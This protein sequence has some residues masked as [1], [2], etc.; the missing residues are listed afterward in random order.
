MARIKG[1]KGFP[2][3][4]ET[5][6]KIS[7]A[8]KGKWIKFN[9]DYCKKENEEKES[10]FKKKNKHFCNIKCYALFRKEKMSFME[11]PAYKGI[12]KEN[13]SKQIYH[14][15]YCRKNPKRISHLKSIRYAREKGAIG[16]HTLEMWENLKIEFDNKCAFCRKKTN[17]TKDH[18]IPLSEGGTN[19]IDN[20]Q[21]L[22]RNCNSR[23]WKFIYQ[24]PELLGGQ[25]E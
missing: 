5:K 1:S 7:L 8:N 3:S 22:C 25:N 15:N 24:N 23:K 6:R 2:L 17:L 21:P 13:Q 11:Q 10:H 14:L 18:I 12:R 4:E 16:S 9:C 20:I 19:F